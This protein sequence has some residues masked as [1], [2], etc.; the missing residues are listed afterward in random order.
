MG[1]VMTLFKNKYRVETTRLKGW[2]YAAAGLYFITIC[3][4]NRV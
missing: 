2:N 4:S 1:K 3:A